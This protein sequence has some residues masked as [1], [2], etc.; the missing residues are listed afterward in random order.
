MWSEITCT[1]ELQNNQLDDPSI[2]LE[3]LFLRFCATE[4]QRYIQNA[5]FHG[6]LCI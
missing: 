5:L 3:T 4:S 2:E 1:R 6:Y